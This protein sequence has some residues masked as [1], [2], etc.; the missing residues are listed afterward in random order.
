VDAGA[1][2]LPPAAAAVRHR[3]PAPAGWA[4]RLATT[5]LVLSLA[6][7]AA[8]AVAAAGGL[9]AQVV[10][11]GSMRPAL[12]PDD[13]LVVQRMAAA[14]LRVGDVVSFAAPA[15]PG[16]VITHRVRSLD[17]TTGGRIAVETR[18][19]ANSASEHWTIARAGS[20]GRVEMVLHGLGALTAW[21][22]DPL[23]R[24]ACA[25]LLSV[26]LAFLA[27]RWVWRR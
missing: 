16:V 26:L 21:A 9:R 14:E 3:A 10:L 22:R 17:S 19:D 7:G 18:G 23:L 27:L 6:L 4:S 11:T 8:V 12:E 5:L 2:S 25:L 1:F 13:M 20:V 24:S 15:Q